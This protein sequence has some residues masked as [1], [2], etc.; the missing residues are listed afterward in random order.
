MSQSKKTNSNNKGSVLTRIGVH[1]TGFS[2]KYMPEPIVF[3][4]TLTF[5][6][7]ILAMLITRLTPFQVLDKWYQGLW[8]LLTFGM[9]MA[10]GII[11]GTVLADSYFLKKGITA[12]AEKP[13]NGP[14]AAFCVALF[15]V[16][17]S[18]VHFGLSLVGGA[19]LAKSIA[20]NLRKKGVPFEY[21]LLAA[22]GYLGQM[23]WATGLSSSIGLL[24]ATP[25]HFL[26]S[27]M[28]V[29]PM[30]NYVFN[31][32]NLFVMAAHTVLL[33]T[34]AYLLHPKGSNV[35]SIPEYALKVFEDEPLP[36]KN[37]SAKESV[38]FMQSLS[39][40][41]IITAAI[42]CLGLF[43]VVYAFATQGFSAFDMNLLNT[44][45]LFSGILLQ[46]TLANYVAAFSKATSSAS[47]IIF[48]F[49]IYAGIMGI[50]K[51]SGLGALLA[52]AIA[53]VSN[54]FTIYLWT[55]LTAALVNLFVPSGGGQWAIQGAVAIE[56][57]KLVGGNLLRS[58]QSVAYGG[59]WA[60]MCQPFWALALLGITGLK[61][62]DILGY[63]TTMMLAAGLL[64]IPTLLLFPL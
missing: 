12:L 26:E 33:P 22:C 46:G 41:R 58:A 28:G 14:Q 5:V 24:I 60:N 30:N 20:K 53:S 15:T 43:Y 56:S 13:K 31:G 25:G 49:P 9:Q 4:V 7:F 17:L 27:E 11:A 19:L 45:M 38:S 64:L 55:F 8:E 36:E 32:M 2:Q 59:A 51:Y 54:S 10:V 44:I 23:T 6:A 42:G 21:G 1:F 57:S 35:N 18:F 47:G 52:T 48:Q 50:I 37:K 61:A 63:S 40:N 39:S 3:A 62:K 29:I 16:L 34:I